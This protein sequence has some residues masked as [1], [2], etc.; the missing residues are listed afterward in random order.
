VEDHRTELFARVRTCSGIGLNRDLLCRIARGCLE[1]RNQFSEAQVRYGD[2]S[3]DF[4]DWLLESKQLQERNGTV[5]LS[6]T[7]HNR[8]F[9]SQ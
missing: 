6:E 3:V 8:P 5:V 2:R 9:A 7:Q 1:V 4:P